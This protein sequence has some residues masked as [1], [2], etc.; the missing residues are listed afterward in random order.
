[1]GNDRLS[2]G[3]LRDHADLIV[4][5]SQVPQQDAVSG[6]HGRLRRRDGGVRG[7]AALHPSRRRA[8]SAGNRRRDRPAAHVQHRAAAGARRKTWRHDGLRDAHH[9][10]SPR[11][12]ALVRGISR[13]GLRLAFD[14]PRVVA[15]PRPFP[16]SR[17]ADCASGAQRREGRF[18]PGSV[19]AC[20]GGFHGAGRRSQRG[21]RRRLDKP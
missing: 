6:G 1:M 18:Q 12:G 21:L 2:A 16:C 14:F 19:P 5:Q 11:G 20:R 7:G 15:F 10:H 9:R 8:D 4:P 3:P 13:G 17:S